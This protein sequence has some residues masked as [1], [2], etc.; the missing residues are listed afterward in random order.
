MH[1]VNRMHKIRPHVGG[2]FAMDTYNKQ[3][4]VGLTEDILHSQKFHSSWNRLLNHITYDTGHIRDTVC[5][6]DNYQLAWQ[7][8]EI[9]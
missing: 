2:S 3:S 8:N 5:K 9:W 6:Y 1:F 4:K 7:W